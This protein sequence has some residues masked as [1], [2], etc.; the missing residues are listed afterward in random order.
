M[1]KRKGAPAGAGSRKPAS[2]KDEIDEDFIREL[3]AQISYV[4]RAMTLLQVYSMP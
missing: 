1:A 3:G 2:K 4:V